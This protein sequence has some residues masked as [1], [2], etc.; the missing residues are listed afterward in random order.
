MERL[1]RPDHFLLTVL[2]T[3]ASR[4]SPQRLLTHRYCWEH[5]Q[6]LLLDVLLAHSS[7]QTLRTV[8]GLL[9]LAEWLP[10]IELKHKTEKAPRSLFAEDRRAWSIVGLAIRQGYMLRLDRGAFR[11][12][13]D[14]ATQQQSDQ[15]RL[16]W[17]CKQVCYDDQK[18][19][20][21]SPSRVSR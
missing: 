9:L 17:H 13:S 6:K 4:D 5:A 11:R 12:S 8:E 15:E 18:V 20:D 3:I 2:L 21:E 1:Q 10:H 7:T 16:I 14:G 19:A